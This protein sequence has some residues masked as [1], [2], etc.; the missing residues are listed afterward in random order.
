[1]LLPIAERK[2]R[3]LLSPVLCG[4]GGA[5]LVLVVT[6]GRVCSQ[7]LHPHLG[8]SRDWGIQPLGFDFT[9]IFFSLWNKCILHS[10]TSVTIQ[11]CSLHWLRFLMLIFLGLVAFLEG[12]L[13]TH[14]KLFFPWK[15]DHFP[16]K[17][18][19]TQAQDSHSTPQ[20]PWTGGHHH[21][22]GLWI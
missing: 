6:L 20:V 8:W 22:V 19:Q 15:S 3:A 9:L 13:G 18:T 1:M 10:Q 14:G 5:G 2:N 11:G 12:L 7:L 17:P 16:G 4:Q 21:R